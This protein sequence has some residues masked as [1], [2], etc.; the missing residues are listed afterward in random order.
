MFIQIYVKLIYEGL[1]HFILLLNL[2]IVYLHYTKNHLTNISKS[3]KQLSMAN[4]RKFNFE[5]LWES[6]Q[7][8]TRA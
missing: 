2:N 4:N 1:C 8:S 7:L 5:K 3:L 6:T